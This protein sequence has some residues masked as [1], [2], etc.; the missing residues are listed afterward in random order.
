MGDD[1]DVVVV[2]VVADGLFAGAGVLLG[3]LEVVR[4]K[5]LALRKWMAR[6]TVLWLCTTSER[7]IGRIRKLDTLLRCV[8]PSDIPLLSGFGTK[9][10]KGLTNGVLLVT[11][12]ILNPVGLRWPG[13]E[14][15]LAL[16]RSLVGLP[17]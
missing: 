4:A 6:V 13:I 9:F 17:I 3:L 14:L 16:S 10:P 11:M 5:C 15:G 12:L 2:A 8:C 1:G 7:A